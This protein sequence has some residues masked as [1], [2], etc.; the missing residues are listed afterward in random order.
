LFGRCDS[1][2]VRVVEKEAI[3]SASPETV[4]TNAPDQRW[5]IPFVNKDEVGAIECAIQIEL[6]NV[7]GFRF[8]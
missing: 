1:A 5:I 8:Q 7:V 2:V 4:S 6:I 3:L